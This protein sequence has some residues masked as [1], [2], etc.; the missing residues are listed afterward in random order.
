[1]KPP[2]FPIINSPLPLPQNIQLLLN[3]DGDCLETRLNISWS[4]SRSKNARQPT[5]IW[6]Q[7]RRAK[8]RKDELIARDLHIGIQNDVDDDNDN[9]QAR[10]GDQV[11]T[12][13]DAA[14]EQFGT[15]T[16]TFVGFVGSPTSEQLCFDIGLLSQADSS[17]YSGEPYINKG[18][19]I[20]PL[21][22]G[23]CLYLPSQQDIELSRHNG[24]YGYHDDLL[25]EINIETSFDSEARNMGNDG[26]NTLSTISFSD[27]QQKTH[28]TEEDCVKGL[29][30]QMEKEAPD[31]TN[32]QVPR[33]QRVMR[34]VPREQRSIYA[35]DA[36]SSWERCFSNM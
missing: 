1:M 8:M 13:V 4:V 11:E 14:Q 17:D 31:H 15:G 36:A 28:S 18:E 3:S 20:T 32:Y 10:V 33:H 25:N 19:G 7:N 6:F 24:L 22:L 26:L 21:S 23:D 5:T 9:R 2:T 34:L 27:V 35:L 30:A 12:V 29:K 16:E